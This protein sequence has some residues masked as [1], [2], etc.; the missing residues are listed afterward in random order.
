VVAPGGLFGERF[1]IQE[2]LGAGAMG[3]VFRALDRRLEREVAVKVLHPHVAGAE[4][5]ARFAREAKVLARIDH[6]GVVRVLDWIVTDDAAALVMELVRGETL[7]ARIDRE[8]PLPVAEAA[9]VGA[10]LFDA[11]AAAHAAGVVHRDV[12]PGNVVLAA[13]RD[14]VEAPRLLDF[15]L[16]RATSL[17]A[18][19][20]TGTLLGTPAYLPPEMLA[21]AEGDARS[22]VYSAGA[23]VYEMLTGA[24]PFAGLRDGELYRAIRDD[25]PPSCASLR[26]DVPPALAASVARAMAKAPDARFASAA[27]ARDA[28]SP[29]A[30][31]IA[32]RAGAEPAEPSPPRRGALLVAA[33]VALL[34]VAPV[35]TAGVT[36]LASRPPP[37]SPPTP[38]RSGPSTSAPPDPSVVAET[39]APPVASA[40][41]SASA[42]ASASAAPSASASAGARLAGATSP[43]CRCR[44][45]LG[46]RYY[47]FLCLKRHTPVCE[48]IS[49]D[50]TT[51]FEPWRPEGWGCDAQSITGPDLATGQPCKGFVSLPA[52]ESKPK[53]NAPTTGTLSCD[54]CDMRGNDYAPAVHLAPC[55][56]ISN[57]GATISGA[58]ECW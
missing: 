25:E 28:L 50:G 49:G 55:E 45:R 3:S 2:R 19:T 39:A 27:E 7:R 37:A 47:G 1:A 54:V 44:M 17:T 58:W 8:G 22:D 30:H 57:T 11:L 38:A 14:G 41:P 46:N 13:R 33:F 18:L 16:A 32:E 56:G 10:A 26:R 15:G 20:E 29:Y 6:P 40:A 21:G 36:F 51:C 42:S 24:R 52:D 43:R 35:T 5:R 53:R 31:T 9:R 48:C 23:V 4:M 34:V 12:K